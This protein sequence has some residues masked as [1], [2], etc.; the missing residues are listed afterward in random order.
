MIVASDTTPISSLL[1]I[2]R[3]NILESL[4]QSV[5]IPPSVKE[6][7]VVGFADD[8]KLKKFLSSSWVQIIHPKN[9]IEVKR[10]LSSLDDGESEAIVLAKELHTDYF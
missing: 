3:L 5:I 10:L 9:L 1:K 6:E 2:D 4:F 7:L 8:T